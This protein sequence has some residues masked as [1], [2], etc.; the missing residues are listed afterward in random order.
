MR[1]RVDLII[2]LGVAFL[3]VEDEW[4]QVYMFHK[5]C[6]P[7]VEP[8]SYNENAFV[9]V[10]FVDELATESPVIFSWTI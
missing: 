6:G 8:G 10:L 5:L 2:F 9:P 4:T 1:K 7:K 3:A